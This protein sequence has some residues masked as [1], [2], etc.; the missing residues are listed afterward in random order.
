MPQIIAEASSSGAASVAVF[1]L[2]FIIAF[3][4]VLIFLFVFWILMLIDALSRKEWKNNDERMMWI[5]ILIV[6]LFIQLWG[7]ASIVYYFVVKRQG[8]N[9]KAVQPAEAQVVAPPAPAP[10]PAPT[11]TKKTTAKTTVNRKK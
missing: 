10:A 9:P 4:G 11:T 1:M 8:S 2:I 5:I 7:I 3:F 6:S